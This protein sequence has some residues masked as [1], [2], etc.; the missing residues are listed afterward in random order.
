MRADALCALRYGNPP[1]VA[2]V[3]G[4]ADTVIDANEM[5]VAAGAG[6]GLQFAP[7][8]REMLRAAIGRAMALWREPAVWRRMQRNAMKTDVSWRRRRPRD[9]PRFTVP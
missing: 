5:A 7:P 9:T 2:R 3:G 1:V 8:T 4:L 6:S